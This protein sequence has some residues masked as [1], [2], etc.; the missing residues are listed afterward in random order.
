MPDKP[1]SYAEAFYAPRKFSCNKWDHYFDIYDRHLARHYGAAPVQ[2]LEIGV[3]NGGSLE[4][5]RMLFGAGSGIYG[6]DINPACK[7]LETAGIADR[8]FTG[9]QTDP[10]LLEEVARTTGALDVIVDD[11]SHV[12]SHMLVSFLNLFPLLRE[13]GV[14]IIEDTHTNYFPGHQESFYGIGLYDYF[15]GLAERLN[16]DFMDPA[17]ASDRFKIPREQRP[18]RDIIDDIG[19]HIFSIT[20]YDSVVAVVKK[21]K[22]EPYRLQR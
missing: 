4:I 6:I 1:K 22:L 13:G 15:K 7:Q 21:V 16:I 3:Q 9:S 17:R 11:G 20:F 18:P 5:A 12:Q 8:V 2:Y 14:Y 10:A 19:R